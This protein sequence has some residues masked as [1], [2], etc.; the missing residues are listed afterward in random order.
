MDISDN[1]LKVPLRVGPVCFSGSLCYLLS[2]SL[3]RHITSNFLFIFPILLPLLPLA[4]DLQLLLW[5]SRIDVSRF[6]DSVLKVCKTKRKMV[7]L[8]L[9]KKGK[10][11]KQ[12]KGKQGGK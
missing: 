4:V 5:Q 8:T 9:W 11:K 2:Q 12:E 6:Q 10:D 3:S 1:Y 7:K